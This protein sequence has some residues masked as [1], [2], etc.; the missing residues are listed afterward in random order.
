MVLMNSDCQ[1]GYSA[2]AISDNFEAF[3]GNEELTRE[4]AE[5]KD[6]F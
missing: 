3:A 2:P 1:Y 4:T 5:T 6:S